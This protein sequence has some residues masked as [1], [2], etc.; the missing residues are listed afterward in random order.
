VAEQEP[1]DVMCARYT[2]ASTVVCL[3]SSPLCRQH[4]RH[5]MY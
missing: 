3:H 1:N 2:K 4:R 5:Y